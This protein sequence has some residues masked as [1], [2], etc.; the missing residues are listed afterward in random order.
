MSY[1]V[2]N[3]QDLGHLRRN[4]LTRFQVKHDHG[5]QFLHDYFNENFNFIK[6][7]QPNNFS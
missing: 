7:G 6:S 4:T 5:N 1:S 3:W 2:S